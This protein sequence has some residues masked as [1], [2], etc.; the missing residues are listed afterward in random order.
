MRLLPEEER[1]ETLAILA[2]NKGDVERALQVRG[3]GGLLPGVQAG[4]RQG[5]RLRVHV[6]LGFV[7]CP[8][9]PC[10]LLLPPLPHRA[11]RL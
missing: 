1:L 6:C 5:S 11:C 9:T 7:T 3:A 2:R 8:R 10:L 4:G